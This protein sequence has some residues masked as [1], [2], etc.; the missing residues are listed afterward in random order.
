MTKRSCFKESCLSFS[1]LYSE[2]NQNCCL[3]TILCCLCLPARVIS[4]TFVFQNSRETYCVVFVFRIYQHIVC[5]SCVLIAHFNA[6]SSCV[7]SCV[8]CTVPQ[9]LLQRAACVLRLG[10]SAPKHA[11]GTSRLPTPEV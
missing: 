11:F 10:I 8:I 2:P 9:L 3:R 1:F 4:L 6:H 5:S 7:G